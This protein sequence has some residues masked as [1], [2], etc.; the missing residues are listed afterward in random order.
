MGKT[1]KLVFESAAGYYPYQT[2]V[3]NMEQ[4]FQNNSHWQT[5]NSLKTLFDPYNIIA[6][7][8]YAPDTPV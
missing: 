1:L 2:D 8:R 4:L 5:V 3:N 6:P 7:G